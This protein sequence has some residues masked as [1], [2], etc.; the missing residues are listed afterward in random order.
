MTITRRSFLGGMAVGAPAVA[1]LVLAK[2]EATPRSMEDE[3]KELD[4]EMKF[5]AEIS[6][7]YVVTTS[8]DLMGYELFLPA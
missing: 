5:T 4:H 1:A 8:T 3:L 6:K 7:F 2:K